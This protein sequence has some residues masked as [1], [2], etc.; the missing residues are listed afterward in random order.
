MFCCFTQRCQRR[1]A[2]ELFKETTYT[3]ADASH[4]SRIHTGTPDLVEEA[5]STAATVSSEQTDS[6]N[7]SL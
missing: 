4:I 6:S 1:F 3:Y 5:P 7:S 2:D